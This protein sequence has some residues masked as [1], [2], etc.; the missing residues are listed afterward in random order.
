MNKELLFAIKRTATMGATVAIMLASTSAAFADGGSINTNLKLATAGVQGAYGYNAPA[1]AGDLIDFQVFIQ[2][3]GT[4]TGTHTQFTQNFDSRLQYVEG[5]TG[6]RSKQANGDV[7]T[8]LS[9]SKIDKNGSSVTWHL[10]DMNASPDA[11]VYVYYQAR[12]TS[13]VSKFAIGSTVLDD[14]AKVSFDG[15]ATQTNDATIVVTR[16]Q[17][18]T[19]SF[20]IVQKVRDAS[21]GGNVYFDHQ[22]GN[23]G[24][25]DILNY[26]LVITNTGTAA[27]TDNS[28]MVKDILPAG[29]TYAGNAKIYSSA[30]PNGLGVDM[31]SIVSAGY[32]LGNI[33]PGTPNQV[34]LAF[35][36]KVTADCNLA[37]TLTNQGQLFYQN[38]L[39]TEDDTSMIFSCTRSLIISEGV[40]NTSG[41]YVHQVS[42]VNTG[43]TLTYKINVQNN[44]TSTLNNPVTWNVLPANVT[45]VQNSLTIDNE[46]MNRAD[47]DAFFNANQGI[48]LTN[49]TPG[50]GKQI[51]FQV[52]VVCQPQNQTLTDTAYAKSDTVSTI[53]ATALADTNTQICV[54]VTPTPAPTP[55]P[56][57][58]TPPTVTPTTPATHAPVPVT[59][60][61]QTGPE[62]ALLIPGALSGLGLLAR[63]QLLA[64]QALKKAIRGINVL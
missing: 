58:T 35:D 53:S 5:S 33:A 46:V 20:S 1:H 22:T 49:F 23:V 42:G 64:R 14:T 18:G 8:Q 32:N 43:D 54:T 29:L 13:D 56:T 57:P 21:N 39:K 52:K 51:S 31:G 12:L 60:L 59:Q 48:L 38:A 63:R 44:A 47:Q 6:I 37:T 17:T 55:V 16:N 62:L 9:E 50:L 19:P 30:N 41:Q 34:T 36:A 40:L 15:V 4:T 61:P 26:E 3:M 45:Y 28:L 27:P 24:P 25:N 2:N 7:D 11:A 10:N